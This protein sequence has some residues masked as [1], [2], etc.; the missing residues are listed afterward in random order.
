MLQ[1]D[2]L[3]QG[4]CVKFA[5]IVKASDLTSTRLLWCE[6]KQREK[7]NVLPMLTMACGWEESMCSS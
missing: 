1:I 3:D 5:R 2:I 4:R 6:R 7:E